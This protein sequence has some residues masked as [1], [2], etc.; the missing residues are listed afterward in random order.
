MTEPK[1]IRCPT[2]HGQ[3]EIRSEARRMRARRSIHSWIEYGCRTCYADGYIT[4]SRFRLLY[5]QLSAQVL[6]SIQERKTA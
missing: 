2:C 6:A 1:T 3:G 5:P 4:E